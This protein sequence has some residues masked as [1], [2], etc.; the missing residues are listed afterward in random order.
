MV[1]VHSLGGIQQQKNL[2]KVELIKIKS[3]IMAV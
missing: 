1:N 2:K 3:K